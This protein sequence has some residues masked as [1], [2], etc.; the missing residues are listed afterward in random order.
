MKKVN[1]ILPLIF[2]VTT[3]FSQKE[4]EGHMHGPD[5]RHVVTSEQA[6]TGTTFI[7]SHHDMRIE[8]ADGKTILGAVVN[9]TIAPKDAPN[10]PIHTEKN[11]YEP[12]NEIYG[13]HMSYTKPGEYILKQD[14]VLPGGRKVAVEFPVF[15][16]A[17]AVGAAE[18]PHEH[19][20][21][22]WPVIL[23][24]TLAGAAALY[25]AY[26]A[27]RNSRTSG[28]ANL[29]AFALLMTVAPTRAWAGEDEP[30]HM[31]GADGRH[32][33]T[34]KDAPTASGPQ[35]R[36]YPGPNE[37][38]SA[39]KSVGDVKFVLEI[40]NEE[41]APDPDLVTVEEAQTKL[42][43]L[44][45]AQAEL[46]GNASGLQATGRVSA[47][48]NGLV[49]VNSRTGG[50]VL[51]LGALPGTSV[52]KGQM[53]AVI[54]SAEL[55]EAQSAFRRANADM[56]QILAGVKVAEAG[57]AAARTEVDVAE[58]TLARQNQLARAG[59]FAS[60]AMERA[61]AALSEAQASR[62]SAQAEVARLDRLVDRLA[63]GV[64]SGVVAERDLD[65]AKSELAAAKAALNNS[66]T[67][68]NL[69]KIALDREENI[70]RQGLRNAREVD[71]ARAQ[72]ELS[73]AGQK[74][75][76]SRLLQARADVTRAQ[77]AIR[78]ARDQIKL[79]GGAPGGGHTVTITAPISAQVGQRLVSAGQTIAAGELLYDLLNAD[80]VWVVVDVFEKDVPKVKLGQ[81]I[82]VVAD[83]YPEDDYEGEVAFIHNEV[84]PQTRT[85][86]VRIVLANPGERLKQ[87]MFVR[88]MLG[89]DGDGGVTVP[90]SA[91][92][93]DKGLDVVFVEEKAGVFRRTLVQVK[94]SFGNRLLVDGVEAGRN[95]VTNGS[96]QLLA[97]AGAK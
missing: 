51:R 45:T 44:Q 40:E 34:E 18:A 83:A 46:S 41:M 32:I 58:R 92:Q 22:N 24:G 12:E 23:G 74:S 65:R 55:A 25:F 13:S 47:N 77:S 9:S 91:V 17:V 49:K 26:R 82:K 60:P 75:A 21:L 35:L 88:V 14:V 30:G 8:G 29:V 4:E 48:P 80:V 37:A 76:S 79:L 59:E 90:A 68:A 2:C 54:E 1:T 67:E 42:I 36:A 93:S 95:V 53:L 27:G 73:R 69:A 97:M 71:A 87:N 84:D 64:A 86:A 38:K 39:T 6:K 15:V 16:P 31:H 7:L 61:R 50:R 11:A 57:V 78:V 66:T 81:T 19:H 89:G 10:A 20:G 56:T 5:G 96:Y 62:A 70:N 3:A 63:Q 85:T 52:Q 94:G 72:A 33:V 43:G 28:I